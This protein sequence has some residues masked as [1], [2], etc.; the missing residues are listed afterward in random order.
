MT[1]YSAQPPGWFA[2][3]KFAIWAPPESSV[4]IHAV[5]P[6]VSM[7]ATAGGILA[8]D[9]QKWGIICPDRGATIPSTPTKRRGH[10]HPHAVALRRFI[11]ILIGAT[12]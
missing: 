3:E 10:R 4:G 1:S 2:S 7:C 12:P 6:G 5:E 9:P 11:S 8:F